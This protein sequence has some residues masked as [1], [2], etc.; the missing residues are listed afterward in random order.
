MTDPSQTAE[1][2]PENQLIFGKLLRAI[3]DSF[4]E[5]DLRDLC[6]ELRLDFENLLEPS[7]R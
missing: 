7:K 2:G 4:S 5:D 3:N 6:F 1:N